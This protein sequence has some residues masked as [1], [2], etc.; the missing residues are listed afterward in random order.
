MVA[1]GSFVLLASPTRAA[2]V[3]S[4]PA[5]P[6]AV[7]VFVGVLESRDDITGTF[8]IV[9]LRAGSLE[10]YTTPTAGALVDIRYGND[11]K[12]LS[13][14]ESYLVGAGTDAATLVLSSS[15]RKS[16][17][18]FGGNEI[19]GVDNGGENCPNLENPIRT[20]HVDGTSIDSGIFTSFFDSKVSLSIAILAPSL[21]FL[22]ILIALVLGRRVVRQ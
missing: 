21:L 5:P 2:D 19:A 11:V 1:L 7:G 9:Q 15:V 12:F 20:L 3:S 6:A 18:L 4:C 13:I 14:G 8:R 17:A 22:A 16:E 10:G